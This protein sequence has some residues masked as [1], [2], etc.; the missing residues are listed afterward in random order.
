MGYDVYDIDF[1]KLVNWLTPY[2]LRDEFLLSLL[3]VQ[4]YSIAQL[5]QLFIRFIAAKI[6]QLKITPQVCY[7][8]MLLNDSFDFTLRRIR[9][10]DAIWY[11][12]TSLY[13]EAE[14]KP[15]AL[16]LEGEGSPTY[17]YTDSEAGT[18]K[19]DFIVLVPAGLI[20][21]S[22]EMRG[23]VDSYKLSGTHYKIQIV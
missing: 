1:K 12:P 13:Q 7:L 19:D 18:F 9:I 8:E 5:H 21:N 17:L 10:A 14:L 2:P 3:G 22:L 6:Y 15:V 11:L 16:N 20:F 23:K 4:V